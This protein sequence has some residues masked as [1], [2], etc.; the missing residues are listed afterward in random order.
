[1]TYNDQNIRVDQ[2][3][4]SPDGTLLRFLQ[5]KF[6]IGII[7][8]FQDTSGAQYRIFKTLFYCFL[9]FHF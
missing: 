3:L 1:M 5:Q 2:A 4:Q 7:D 8:E 6:K 9:A